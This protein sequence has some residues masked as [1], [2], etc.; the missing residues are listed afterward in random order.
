ML[1]PTFVDGFLINFKSANISPTSN[2]EDEV[3]SLLGQGLQQRTTINNNSVILNFKRMKL[4]CSVK[5]DTRKSS[6]FLSNQRGLEAKLKKQI[7]GDYEARK[8]CKMDNTCTQ[9]THALFITTIYM[10]IRTYLR[11]RL[12]YTYRLRTCEWSFRCRVSYKNK[13]KT[14]LNWNNVSPDCLQNW[15]FTRWIKVLP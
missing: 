7:T 6:A 2:Q 15:T 1:K 5:L 12:A 4:K 8:S 13:T 3:Q 14:Y 11:Q 10:Y 9:G